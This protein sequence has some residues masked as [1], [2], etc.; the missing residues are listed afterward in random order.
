MDDTSALFW[1]CW[2]IAVGGAWSGYG[3]ST[4]AMVGGILAAV[5]AL[6]E[7]S[8]ERIEDHASRPR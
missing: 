6:V 8:L 1:I 7:Y 4:A 3:F 5:A 2:G